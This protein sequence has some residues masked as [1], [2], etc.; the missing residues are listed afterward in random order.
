M[1]EPSSHGLVDPKSLS[2]EKWALSLVSALDPELP[3]TV[4]LPIM[5]SVKLRRHCMATDCGGS[6]ASFKP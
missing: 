4:M 1:K 3:I 6:K 2:A 5:A